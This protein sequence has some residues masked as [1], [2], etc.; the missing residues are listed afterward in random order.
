MLKRWEVKVLSAS[1]LVLRS[2]GVHPL[3][4]LHP[5]TCFFLLSP[6]EPYFIFCR[7]LARQRESLERAQS[8][9]DAVDALNAKSKHIL[10][11]MSGLWGA[12]KNMFKKKPKDVEDVVAEKASARAAKL[13]KEKKSPSKSMQSGEG[14]CEAEDGDASGAARGNKDVKQAMTASAPPRP[15][16]EDLLEQISANV[17]RLGE[18]GKEI[19]SELNRQ[20]KQIDDLNTSIEKTG[21]GLKKN[22][23]EA[24]RQ[25]R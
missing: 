20:D 21:I 18:M 1:L 7:S 10:V 14:G 22:A 12:F 15:E 16:E 8:Q 4:P 17:A 19:G 6:P 23:R 13:A 5:P 9:V 11:G 2:I 25:A 3:P 24:S